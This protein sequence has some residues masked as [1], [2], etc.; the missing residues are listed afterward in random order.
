[1]NKYR[2]THEL[3]GAA[4]ATPAWVPFR[5]MASAAPAGAPGVAAAAPHQAGP[6]GRGV[7]SLG[8]V[9]VGGDGSVVRVRFNRSTTRARLGETWSQ[10]LGPARGGTLAV[11]VPG[12]CG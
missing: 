4:L 12:E 11:G 3:R 8:L 7:F 9:H 2:F 5:S 1:M 6:K 10:Y